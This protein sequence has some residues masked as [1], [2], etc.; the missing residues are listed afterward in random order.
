MKAIHCLYYTITLDESVSI[1]VK[2]NYTTTMIYMNFHTHVHV[3]SFATWSNYVI[4]FLVI[5]FANIVLT[6]VVCTIVLAEDAIRAALNDYKVKQEKK[7]GGVVEEKM[8][9]S[10]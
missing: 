9:A 2:L 8:E 4:L 5:Q 10:A 7:G 6:S 3:V 1:N